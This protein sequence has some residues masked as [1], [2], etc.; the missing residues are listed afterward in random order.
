[1]GFT[2]DFSFV[3]WFLSFFLAFLALLLGPTTLALGVAGPSFFVLGRISC[4]NH[5][6]FKWFW[7]IR[8]P[9]FS[10]GWLRGSVLKLEHLSL[11]FCDILKPGMLVLVMCCLDPIG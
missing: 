4:L 9:V 7:C 11:L 1:M 5:K 8:F 6:G 3:F 2:F 10:T